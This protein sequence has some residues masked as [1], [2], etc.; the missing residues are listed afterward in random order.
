[1]KTQSQTR[2]ILQAHV[3]DLK[4]A[5]EAKAYWIG[6]V[7]ALKAVVKELEREELRA[8]LALAKEAGK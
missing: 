4:N 7:S 6:R 1:M 3:N 5:Q 2:Q 8:R